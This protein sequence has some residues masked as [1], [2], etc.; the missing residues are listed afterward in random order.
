MEYMVAATCRNIE[1]A[2]GQPLMRVV[3]IRHGE[4]TGNIGIFPADNETLE[5]GLPGLIC[6]S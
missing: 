6:T 1:G 4:S 3:F 2:K 5:L